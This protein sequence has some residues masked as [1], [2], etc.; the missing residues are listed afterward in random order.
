MIDSAKSGAT[1]K[2]I[3]GAGGEYIHLVDVIGILSLI[4]GNRQSYGEVFNMAGSRRYRDSELARQ[5]IKTTASV[6]ELELIKDPGGQMVSVNTG[7]L[8]HKLG[9]HYKQVD[10]LPSVIFAKLK[11][12]AA[13]VL[14]LRNHKC[15]HLTTRSIDP[16]NNI[17]A[18]VPQICAISLS[19]SVLRTNLAGF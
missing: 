10:F 15:L 19:R 5:I 11:V 6:S 3:Q 17:G 2:A 4:L 14:A 1:V 7:K 18:S 13:F 8:R 9:Y 12:S 16:G